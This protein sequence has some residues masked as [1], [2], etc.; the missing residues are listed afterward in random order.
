MHL[1]SRAHAQQK[2]A[3]THTHKYNSKIKTL[4]REEKKLLVSILC[5]PGILSCLRVILQVPSLCLYINE[6]AK[7][8]ASFL[9]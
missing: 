3:L 2:Y 1:L 4:Q 9:I 8:V 7:V 6:W 5:G